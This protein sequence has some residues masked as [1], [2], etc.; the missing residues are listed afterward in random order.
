VLRPS[1]LSLSTKNQDSKRLMEDSDEIYAEVA[2]RKQHVHDLKLRE[3]VWTPFATPR[4]IGARRLR[5]RLA[6]ANCIVKYS[7]PA[8]KVRH[9]VHTGIACVVQARKLRF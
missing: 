5:I 2:R 9:D 6:W 4:G 8:E 7:T 3:I 1:T